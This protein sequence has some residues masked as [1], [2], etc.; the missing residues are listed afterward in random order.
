MTQEEEFA[1]MLR[2]ALTEY[3]F[4]KIEVD[5]DRALVK[6]NREVFAED[7]KED[8]VDHFFSDP[9]LISILRA[10]KGYLPSL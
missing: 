9:K 8:K 3:D 5:S 2:E 6:L 1:L 7:T 4:E 10:L